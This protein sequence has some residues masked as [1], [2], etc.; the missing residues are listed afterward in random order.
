[1]SRKIRFLMAATLVALGAAAQAAPGQDVALD[2]SADAAK[3]PTLASTANQQLRQE[4]VPSAKAA[5]VSVKAQADADLA[6]R[7]ARVKGR[8]LEVHRQNLKGDAAARAIRQQTTPNTIDH[9]TAYGDKDHTE[10]V[11]DLKVTIKK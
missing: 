1:M 6:A 5:P 2:G 10:Q 7:N 8:H 11:T 3:K 4:D 9:D